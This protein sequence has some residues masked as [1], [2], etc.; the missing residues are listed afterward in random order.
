MGFNSAFKGLKP[1]TYFM[2]HQL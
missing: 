2:Y 1:K